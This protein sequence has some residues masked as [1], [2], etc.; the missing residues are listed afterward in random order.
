M[1]FIDHG[2]ARI[3]W[4]RCDMIARA[5]ANS[6]NGAIFIASISNRPVYERGTHRFELA[7]DGGV[8][9]VTEGVILPRER[10]KLYFYGVILPRQSLVSLP[11]R[12][13][14]SKTVIAR[15]A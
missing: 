10:V 8:V 9:V 6:K 4:F 7:L 1:T 13:F 15:S 3:L 2:K 12:D 5:I 14:F 11:S